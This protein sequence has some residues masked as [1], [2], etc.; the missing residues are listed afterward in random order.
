MDTLILTEEELKIY[1]QIKEQ[2][3]AKTDGELIRWLLHD[4]KRLTDNNL[5]VKW[6]DDPIPSS[7]DLYS[8]PAVSLGGGLTVV[9][10]DKPSKRIDLDDVGKLDLGD[11]GGAGG[12]GGIG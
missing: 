2:S 10:D 8:A 3:K 12:L 6:L 5:E 11:I 7:G 1:K 9:D 4:W